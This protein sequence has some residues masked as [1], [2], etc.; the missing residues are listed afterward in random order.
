MNLLRIISNQKAG[1]EA[2]DPKALVRRD[3]E[4][5]IDLDSKLAQVVIGVR[6]SGKAYI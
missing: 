5:L 1:I 4:S 6:R 2:F 3:E